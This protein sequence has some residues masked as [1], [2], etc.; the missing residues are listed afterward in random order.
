MIPPEA[1]KVEKMESRHYG[2]GGAGNGM[3]IS[4]FRN[5]FREMNCCG[6]LLLSLS[7]PG[8]RK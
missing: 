7:L 1:T 3:F 2:R 8:E 5:P 4:D 6:G